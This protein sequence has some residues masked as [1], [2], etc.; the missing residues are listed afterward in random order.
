M[1]KA[2]PTDT[3]IDQRARAI[4][5]LAF[6]TG[7]RADALI[8][9]RLRHIDLKGRKA[10]HDGKESRAD[11]WANEAGVGGRTLVYQKHGAGPTA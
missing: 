10:I 4:F 9:V 5:A 3:L 2:M 6:L 1:L 8:T 7:F 11:D